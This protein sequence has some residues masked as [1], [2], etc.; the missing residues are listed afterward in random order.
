MFALSPERWQ[1]LS[2]YLDDALDMCK[3]EREALL[4]SLRAKDSDLAD[5]LQS[6]LD[7]HQELD[8]EKFLEQDQ[9]PLQ[10]FS[11][12]A[13]QVLGAYTLV[14]P[15][16]QGGM[17]SVWLARRNDGRFERQAAVKFLNVALIGRGGEERFKKR[18][19]NS[20][21]AYPSPYRRTAGR[22]SVFE[23]PALSSAGVCQRSA[24]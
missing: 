1:A 13:G 7:E 12:L 10:Q 18:R 6:L 23:W 11:A 16:G 21:P 22:G 17:G 2:P 3:E 5:A 24:H 4:A 14:S 19:K 20:R 9:V 15:L 8:R